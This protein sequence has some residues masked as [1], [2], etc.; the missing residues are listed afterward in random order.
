[1][2]AAYHGKFKEE[3]VKAEFLKYLGNLNG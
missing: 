1:V 3:S 2:T